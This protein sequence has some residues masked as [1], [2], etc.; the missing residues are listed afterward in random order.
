MSDPQWRARHAVAKCYGGHPFEEKYACLTDLELLILYRQASFDNK[1]KV[2]D[3]IAL[4]KTLNEA[5]SDKFDNMLEMLLM[6]TNPKM[7]AK[8]NELVGLKEFESEMKD[9]DYASIFEETMKAVPQ[10]Y[11]IIEEDS[12]AQ[13]LSEDEEAFSKF[14]T[15]FVN[16]RESLMKSIKGE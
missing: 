11:T 6:F 15:G 1:E 14:V 9:G 3:K 10:T 4:I 13:E 5:W 16:K 12:F 2:D 7:Y 8:K